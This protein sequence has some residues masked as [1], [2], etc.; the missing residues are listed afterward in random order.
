M[1]LN[2]PIQ[3]VIDRAE[4]DEPFLVPTVIINPGTE[5]EELPLKRGP[6]TQPGDPSPWPRSDVR[7]WACQLVPGTGTTWC[8]WIGVL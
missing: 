4:R 6:G 8:T 2:L 3:G 5:F 7:G 1:Q